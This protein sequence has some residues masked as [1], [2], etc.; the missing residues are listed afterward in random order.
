[1]TALQCTDAAAA[2]PAAA[3]PAAAAPVASSLTLLSGDL[4]PP[5][6][7]P[8]QLS[9]ALAYFADVL[10]SPHKDALLALASCARDAEEAERLK[11]LASA[12]GK[13]QYTD[14]IAKQHRSLMEVRRLFNWLAGILGLWLPA[15]VAEVA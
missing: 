7:G 3:P 2:L 11:L 15:N 6:P 4:D 10:S 5:F 13:A 8:I 1:M 12:A 14:Y 9:T